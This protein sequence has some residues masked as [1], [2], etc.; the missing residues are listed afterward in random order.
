M[1]LVPADVLG[2][3]TGVELGLRPFPEGAWLLPATRLDTGPL[4]PIEKPNP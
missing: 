4:F 1:S 2:R 3:A